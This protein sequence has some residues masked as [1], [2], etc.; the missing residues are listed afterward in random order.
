MDYS[1]L[2]GHDDPCPCGSGRTFGDCCLKSR[3]VQRLDSHLAGQEATRRERFGEVRAAVHAD[4]RGKKWIAVGNQLLSGNWRFFPDFL[5]DYIKV[6]LTPPL[7]QG[8]AS[9][10]HWRA[11]S[12]DAVVRWDVSS[13]AGA[14][15]QFDGDHVLRAGWLHVGLSAS[16]P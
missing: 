6:A 2:I 15:R 4:W 1:R 10:T 14:T 13:S 5:Q 3:A 9:Q 7:G 12:S 8:R 11:A 16:G